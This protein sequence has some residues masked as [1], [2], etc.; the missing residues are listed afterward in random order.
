MCIY[1]HKCWERC[2][3]WVRRRLA[4]VHCSVVIVVL[5]IFTY[6]FAKM[7]LVYPET[8]LSVKSVYTCIVLRAQR[9]VG[10][11]GSRR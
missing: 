6:I 8:Y 1:V 2:V 4:L 11:S 5:V 7:Y 9:R 10:N 3:E